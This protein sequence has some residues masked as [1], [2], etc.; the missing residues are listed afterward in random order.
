M[1]R[2]CGGETFLTWGF[3]SSLTGAVCATLHSKKFL[4]CE[5]SKNQFKIFERFRNLFLKIFSEKEYEKK[6]IFNCA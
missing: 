6:S 4:R 5:R 3:S 2:D 1:I